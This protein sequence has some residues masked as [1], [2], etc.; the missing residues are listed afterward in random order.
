MTPQVYRK[1]TMKIQ[2]LGTDQ[3]N[4]EALVYVSNK[5]EGFYAEMITLKPS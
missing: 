4:V 3:F 2:I 5:K 1:E